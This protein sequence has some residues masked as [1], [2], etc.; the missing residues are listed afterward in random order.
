MVGEQQFRHHLVC[1]ENLRGIICLLFGKPCYDRCTLVAVEGGKAGGW[2]KA[3]N[4]VKIGWQ[5]AAD[6]PYKR[7][8]HLAQSHCRSKSI[9]LDLKFKSQLCPLSRLFSPPVFDLSHAVY[10]PLVEG[11]SGTTDSF[12]YLL[13]SMVEP[14]VIVSSGHTMAY[15]DSKLHTVRFESKLQLQTTVMLFSLVDR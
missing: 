9:D 3:C 2:V 4:G 11:G 14:K 10:R 7:I 13:G 1:I 5:S 12:T 8:P 6:W 15:R